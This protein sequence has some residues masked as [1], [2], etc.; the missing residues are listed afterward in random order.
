MSSYNSFRPSFHRYLLEGQKLMIDKLEHNLFPMLSASAPAYEP[1]LVRMPTGTGKTGIIALA[2]FFG[3]DKGSTLIVTPWKNLCEQLEDDLQFNATHGFWYSL[4][5]SVT[6]S[7]RVAYESLVKSVVFKPLRFMP[8]DA[9]KILKDNSGKRTVLISTL[10]GLQRLQRDHP[11]T[12]DELKK[13]IGLVIVDEGHYEP[14]VRW[15]RSVRMLAKP[16]LILTATPYRNDLKLFKVPK[17]QVFHYKHVQAEAAATFPLRNVVSHSLKTPFSDK[18]F[19]KLILEFLSKWRQS[20][21]KLPVDQPRA[22]ICCPNKKYIKIALEIVHQ[23]G[24]SAMAFHERVEDDDYPKNSPL[25]L[26][27]VKTVP[28]AKTNDDEIWIHQHKLTEGLDDSRFCGILFTYPLLNDRKLVQQVGRILRHSSKPKAGIATQKAFVFHCSTYRFD[29]VWE[30]YRNFE[31]QNESIVTGD[32]YRKIVADFLSL[33]PEY[34]YFGKRFRKKLQPFPPQVNTA[35]KSEWEREARETILTPP[36]VLVIKVGTSFD[37][38]EFVESCSIGLELRDS[39]VLNVDRSSGPTINN[40]GLAMWLYAMIANSDILLEHSSYEMTVETRFVYLTGGYLFI[41]DTGGMSMASDDY[42]QDYGS[43]AS[44]FDLTRA[45]DKEYIV[46]Q[47][48]LFNTQSVSTV[49]RRTVRQ[50]NNLSE[51]PYQIS[52]KKFIV[53]NL[54]ARKRKVKGDRYFGLTTGRISDRLVSG[55]RR[56][57]TIEQFKVWAGDLAIA[58][59][60]NA[61]HEFMD[62]Y[63]RLHSAPAKAEPYSLIFEPSPDPGEAGQSGQDDDDLNVRWHV[64][65]FEK[66]FS[67]DETVFKIDA[68]PADKDF[69]FKIDIVLSFD[70]VG[71]DLVLLEPKEIA[72]NLVTKSAQV[73]VKYDAKSEIFK[74]KKGTKGEIEAEFR[75]DHHSIAHIFGLLSDRVAITLVDSSLVYNSRQFFELDYSNAEAKF[76]AYFTGVKELKTVAYEKIQHKLSAAKKGKLTSWP[77][78]SVFAR[79]ISYVLTAGDFKKYDW[80][81]CDDLNGEI[82]DF[83]VADMKARKIAF[84]H[85]KDGDGKQ[86][87]ASAFHDLVSQASKNLAYLKTQRVPPN[88]KRWTKTDTWPKTKIKRWLKG[89]ARL[90]SKKSLWDLLNREI[91]NHPAGSTEVWLVMGNGLDLTALRNSFKTT[92][93]PAEV[94]PLLHLLD[95]LVANCD[96]ARATLKVFAHE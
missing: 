95:G 72:T 75:N 47:A 2:S 54:K 9:G 96:E 35:S 18:D 42:L 37:F 4:G 81:Y 39:V 41:G 3:N 65:G 38:D 33:Q 45:L 55:V 67:V 30:S 80:L 86:L 23:Q 94:G 31:Q 92:K 70:K 28:S 17:G 6:K 59:Q 63:A 66:P 76:D 57:F 48:S 89:A 43:R 52:E 58:L 40:G 22:I 46:N 51:A 85:C 11:G 13:A 61:D 87:S 10:A 16:T 74:F 14:A 71:N 25:K 15:G 1:V 62:R 53:H 56:E 20:K 32:H 93:Q 64:K 83:I 79:T 78:E 69:P 73:L 34:E 27:F 90:G 50:A 77:P 68:N 8:S 5:L 29:K 12:Y 24:F 26:R 49:V 44:Y 36:S 84:I 7:E 91:L 60:A 88:I 21:N 82:A 19:G